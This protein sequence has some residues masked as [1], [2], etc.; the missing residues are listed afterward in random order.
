MLIR[1][2]LMYFG[3]LMFELL[4]MTQTELW[5]FVP[6]VQMLRGIGLQKMMQLLQSQFVHKAVNQKQIR[7]EI[8]IAHHTPAN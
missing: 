6:L 7:T 3:Q 8:D 2:G 5:R 1:V 4:L